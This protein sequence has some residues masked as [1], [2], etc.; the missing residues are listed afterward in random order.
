MTQAGKIAVVIPFYQRTPGVLAK[1]I[2]SV[3]DQTGVENVLAIVVDDGS[4]IKAR[5]ELARFLPEAGDRLCIVE[6]VNG[7]AAAARNT[8]L[9]NVPADADAV[10]FLDSDD[11]WTVDHLANAMFALNNGFDLYFSDFYQLNQT[12]TAF[13]RAG[14]IKVADH[15]LIAGSEHIHE[16]RGDMVDQIITGNILGTSVIV[17]RREVATAIRFRTYF[18]HTGEEYLYWIELARR[19]RKIAFSDKPEC[20]YEAGVNIYSES[21]WGKEKYLSVIV[22]DVKYRQ[23]ILSEYSPTATQRRFLED[24]IRLLRRSF[25]AGLVHRLLRGSLDY[26]LLGRYMKVDKSYPINIWRS[27]LELLW[28]SVSGKSASN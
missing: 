15:P 14:R 1:T 17:C 7:G 3:L 5:D 4:P 26:S 19:S 8:G 24:R 12:V 11:I 28:E 13:N 27:V 20:R 18:R 22:D 21:A 25:T 9:D 10:A 23:I 6:Q 2:R 16:Y